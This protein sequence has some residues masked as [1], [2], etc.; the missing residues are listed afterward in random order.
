MKITVWS[1][2]KYASAAPY[3]YILTAGNSKIT[4][5]LIYNMHYSYVRKATMNVKNIT[6]SGSHYHPEYHCITSSASSGE[7]GRTAAIRNDALTS[8]GPE[9]TRA[10][11]PIWGKIV[12]WWCI[13]FTITFFFT[14]YIQYSNC[15]S[16][17]YYICI[18]SLIHKNG[19]Y[20]FLFPL[21]NIKIDFIYIF[22]YGFIENW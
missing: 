21:N 10:Y 2:V 20:Y 19:N 14:Q 12:K 17:P 16:L 3:Y 18:Y 8:W 15:S 11:T 22:L 13:D 5:I 4:F 1:L 7:D 6:P 9:E